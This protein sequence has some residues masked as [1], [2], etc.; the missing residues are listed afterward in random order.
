MNREELIK[1]IKKDKNL[2]RK[3]VIGEIEKQ[4]MELNIAISSL[5]TKKIK[6]ETDLIKIK[7]LGG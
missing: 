3:I 1:E 7:Y 5:E 2:M 6:L 4:I